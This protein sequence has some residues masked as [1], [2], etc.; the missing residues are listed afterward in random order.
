[1][2]LDIFVIYGIILCLHLCTNDV[3]SFYEG[4]VQLLN[5]RTKSFSVVFD[6]IFFVVVYE[7]AFTQLYD[8]LYKNLLFVVRQLVYVRFPINP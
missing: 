2:F 5:T 4:A 3:L 1:M 6:M 7:H 8:T